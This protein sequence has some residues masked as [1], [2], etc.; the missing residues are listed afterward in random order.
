MH[1]GLLTGL[2]NMI[3][4]LNQK[5]TLHV[6]LITEIE[7]S[8]LQFSQTEE[9]NIYRIIQESINNAIKHANC[10]EVN[11]KLTKKKSTMIFIIQ[12]NGTGFVQPKKNPGLGIKNIKTR[13]RS[14]NGRLKIKSSK[15]GLSMEIK[16]PLSKV[17]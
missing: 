1:F 4:R 13:V 6:N 16:I 9:L 15:K 8:D 11:V 14:I 7:K 2:E 10:T 5:D 17:K 3:A 12:D